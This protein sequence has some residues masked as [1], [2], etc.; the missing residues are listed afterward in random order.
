MP[1]DDFARVNSF[2]IDFHNMHIRTTHTRS[3][4]NKNYPVEHA[5][6][7]PKQSYTPSCSGKFYKKLFA[8]N[9]MLGPAAVQKKSRLRVH[10]ITHKI[11]SIG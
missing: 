5:S 11:P 1:A 10:V 4:R 7:T 3:P 2:D 9:G 8:T 6:L